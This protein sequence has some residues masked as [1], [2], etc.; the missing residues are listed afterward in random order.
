MA[1]IK[2]L[3]KQI[4]WYNIAEKCTPELIAEPARCFGPVEWPRADRMFE[5]EMQNQWRAVAEAHASRKLSDSEFLS[6][7]G[8]WGDR[9]TAPG[10]ALLRII[11]K[12]Q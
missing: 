2:N 8:E 5:E 3:E 6:G 4:Y 7:Y 10:D 9:M 1:Y 11:Y 12:D